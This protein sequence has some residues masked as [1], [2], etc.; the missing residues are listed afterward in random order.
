MPG[1]VIGIKKKKRD[2]IEKIVT[3]EIKS[4]GRNTG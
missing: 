3:M 1:V 4:N 2:R